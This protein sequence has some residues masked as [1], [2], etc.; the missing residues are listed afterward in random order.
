MISGI[1]TLI[2]GPEVFLGEILWCCVYFES[3]IC[4]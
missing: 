1:I 4:C 2:P 3:D